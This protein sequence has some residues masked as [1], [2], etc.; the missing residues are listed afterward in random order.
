VTTACCLALLIILPPRLSSASRQPVTFALWLAVACRSGSG[1]RA[2]F[3]AFIIALRAHVINGLAGLSL[4]EARRPNHLGLL[5]LG[6]R[7][8]LASL[9]LRARSV[10]C[11]IS[12]N[13]ATAL[14]DTCVVC[15]QPHLSRIWGHSAYTA[16]FM[17]V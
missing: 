10:W 5:G 13:Q 14:H 9:D 7:L 17:V 2:S 8:Y 1:I 11:C 12:Q 3:A 6:T 4:S 16:S 15:V